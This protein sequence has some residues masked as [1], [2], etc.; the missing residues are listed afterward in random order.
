MST[1]EQDLIRW[2]TDAWK[3]RNMVAWYSNRMNEN[4]GTNRLKNRV[5]VDLCARF[6]TGQDVLDVGIGTG[7]ASL[8]LIARG[9]RLA[10][11]DSSQ[12]MLDECRRLAAGQ[13]IEL[14]PGDV[15]AL[16]FGDARFD[17]LISLN[18]M[19][20]FPH[21]ESVLNEWKRVVKPGGRLIFDIYS[22]DQISFARGREITVESL[23]EQEASNFNMHLSSERLVHAANS[24]GLRIVGTVPY[25][26]LFSG[27]YKHWTF[28]MPL[29]ASHWWRRQLSWIVSDDGLLDMAIFLEQEWFAHLSNITTGRFMVVLE[30]TPDEAANLQWHAEQ[31]ALSTR[32]VSEPV[33]LNDLAPRLG[34]TVD[35]WRDRFDRHLESCRNRTVA[36]FLL[37]T[38][39][40]R[41]DAV[42]WLDLAPRNGAI[43]QRWALAEEVDKQ[44][45]RFVRQWH[46]EPAV[47]ALCQSHGVDLGATLEYQLQRKFVAQF[48]PLSGGSNQ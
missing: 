18:V 28:P 44:L 41:S 21:V 25:G 17:S 14:V 29:Q 48:G 7:R 46:Q 1:V 42:D 19:T 8:P 39:L 10:G 43:L 33:R 12:A 36:Y 15:K 3:D 34:M 22:L 32:L 5:E 11:T 37:S 35:A 40:G 26:S 38:F 9:Y 4:S 47:A 6:I 30:N 27:E 13:P 31:M 23:M 2:K 24:A 20:H 16:P 45:Q